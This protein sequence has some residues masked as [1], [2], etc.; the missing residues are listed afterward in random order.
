MT[1]THIDI[2]LKT[3]TLTLIDPQYA[4]FS[5]LIS[6]GINGAGETIGSGCTPRGRLVIK[7]KIGE[8]LPDNSVFVG[9]R[10]TQEIYTPELGQQYP[11]RDWILTRILWLGGLEPHKNRY[12][13]VDTLRRYIYLHGCPEICPM[14][15]AQSHGCIRVR[16]ADLQ[17]IF[18]ASTVGTEI[19]I[20]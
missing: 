11:N 15:I 10:A 18:T 17:H 7:A 16:N 9:R 8:G 14:G 13:T 19:F 1:S 12:G 20:H 2:D 6:S 3:Q 5:C 4:P